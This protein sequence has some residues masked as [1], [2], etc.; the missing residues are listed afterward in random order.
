MLNNLNYKFKYT[1]YGT[2]FGFM[3]PIIAITVLVFER[4]V[5][6]YDAQFNS[7]LLIWIIDLAPLILALFARVAGIKQDN[8]QVILM[9]ERIESEELQK[10]TELELYQSSKLASIGELAA[11]VGHE[12][13][14][15]LAIAVGT[16]Y[17]IKKR[18]IKLHHQDEETFSRIKKIEI[19]NERIRNIVDGLRTYARSDT[20][21][22][23]SISLMNAVSQTVSLL[24]DIYLKEGIIIEQSVPSKDL[25]VT[26]SLGRFQQIIMNLIS[27][28][29]DATE[30]QSKRII[31]ISFAN[32]DKN[33]CL[34]VADN[35]SGMAEDVKSK[36][37]NPFFTTK[38]AGKGTGMGLGIVIKLVNE[39]N[40]KISVESKI[41]I[42]TEFKLVFPM[43]KA[44][45]L[46]VN[47]DH[48]EDQCHQTP[49]P[50]LKIL[51]V[52]DEC[53]IR[54]IIKEI[55]EDL[56]HEVIEAS[57]GQEGLEKV[58]QND[59]DF[60]FTDMKM[61]IMAGPEMIQEICNLNLDNKPFIIAVTGGVTTNFTQASRDEMSNSIDGY[62]LK[63]FT[64][65]TLNRLLHEIY[66]NSK[67]EAA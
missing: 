33:V 22:N 63:P 57:N 59:F 43:A 61:P 56:G 3:F 25:F 13:N 42:G 6:I 39:L 17:A 15:P 24:N 55:M 9:G 12:I 60:V 65:E 53:D 18:L 45:S 28:A 40:G 58:K 26:G 54:E 10:K 2:L 34:S 14:N 35:G 50:C 11:G 62:A 27:N 8:V 21:H 37:F 67:A 44:P 4:N 66:H 64:E 7:G 30:G 31:K 1:I 41:D 20:Q 46:L 36:I 47:K 16:I 51:V 48:E 52:D 38:V 19:A 29:K 5:S 32:C 23:E 49:L